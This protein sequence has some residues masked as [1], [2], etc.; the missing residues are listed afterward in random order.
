MPKQG[1]QRKENEETK[2]GKVPEGWQA[3]SLRL[4]QKDLVPGG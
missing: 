3:N 2:E 1:D 4:R